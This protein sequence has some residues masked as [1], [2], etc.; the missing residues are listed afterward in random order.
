MHN[1]ALSI[2]IS[3][4]NDGV[5]LEHV[6]QLYK[7][8]QPY[9]IIVAADEKCK[10]C[11]DIARTYDCRVFVCAELLD[12]YK[13]HAIGAKE[14]K[15]DILLFVD[16]K[17]GITSPTMK[18]FLQ[19]LIDGTA[20]VVI[21]KMDYVF[22][23][24]QQPPPTVIW[25]QITNHFFH[26]SD[27]K[28][29]S[30]IFVPYAMT[31]QAVDAIHSECLANPVLAHLNIIDHQFR[32]ANHLP[33][34]D[35]SLYSNKKVQT[36]SDAQS[37]SDKRMLG[38]HLN[39]ISYCTKEMRDPRAGYSDGGRRFDIIKE[40]KSGTTK[41]MPKVILGRGK[42]STLYEGKQLS[43][44]IPVQ[45][46]AKLI[47][48]IIEECRKLEPIEIIVVVNG[49][50]DKTAEIAEK[51]EAKVIIYNEKLG[52][53]TGRAVGAYFAEGDI[54]LF[55][56][57]DF[58]ISEEDLTPFVHSVQSGVDLALN[59][60]NHYLTCHTPLHIVTACKYA[61]NLACGRRDLGVGS[62]VAVPHAFSKECIDQLG[63]EALATPVL[64]QVAT[65]M[66]G[67]SVKNVHRVE[68]DKMNRFRP[69]KHFT[70]KRGKLA[71]T[72]SLIVGDHTEALSYLANRRL[73]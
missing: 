65:I 17:I 59:D 41:H 45:N 38:Y 1:K 23:K 29:D 33:I 28:I 14:A 62:T 31:K 35:V 60:L 46:E 71:P 48:S 44:I 11:I 39:A 20:D 42:R 6:I 34:G 51:C 50:I 37:G 52:L 27:L 68:V 18:M 56:D 58:V 10:H 40:L 49:T 73:F 16:S 26:R 61:I 67:H 53:D 19:P 8:L 64:S 4:C 69:D 54:M 72:T 66:N 9:E 7:Q 70:N 57:G 32:I 47:R 25:P 43:V 55:I 2:I 15:G 63:F 36:N 21:N 30:I 12:T 13:G 5:P 22:Y 3:V 24:K